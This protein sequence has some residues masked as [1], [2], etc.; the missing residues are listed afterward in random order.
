MW[1]H[2]R[3]VSQPTSWHLAAF[4]QRRWL[5]TWASLR[6]SRCREERGS[7][8]A[9]EQ[10]HPP[11]LLGPE[12]QEAGQKQARQP[13]LLLAPAQQEE[14]RRPGP[15]CR[16]GAGGGDFSEGAAAWNP[17]RLTQGPSGS[18]GN[19]RMERSSTL[20]PMSQ[21]EFAK[22]DSR[23]RLGQLILKSELLEGFRLG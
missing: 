23:D 19:L 16:R 10:E 5:L 6:R 20:I 22:P 4:A 18:S 12:K 7:P 17:G 1:K 2:S 3:Q 14:G 11:P 21:E 9:A 15:P 13:S 8:P